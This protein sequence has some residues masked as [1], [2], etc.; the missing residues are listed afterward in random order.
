M[1]LKL[2]DPNQK[3]EIAPE[4]NQA[5]V[6]LLESTLADAKA[7]KVTSAILLTQEGYDVTLQTCGEMNAPV[8]FNL[9]DQ[10]RHR[11]HFDR[12]VANRSEP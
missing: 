8:L 10:F 11:Y 7:G 6:G 3:T 4:I 5:L 9:F 2:V 1:T 12:M